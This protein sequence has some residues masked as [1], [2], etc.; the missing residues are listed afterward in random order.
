M[1]RC[2]DNSAIIDMTQQPNSSTT[3]FAP[4][5]GSGAMR[6]RMGFAIQHLLAAAR[7]ARRCGE[8]E[9]ENRGKPIDYFFDEI[10]HCCTA[11]LFFSVASLEA[12]INE[13]FFD[14]EQ[15]FSHQTPDLIAELWS[16]VEEKPILDKYQ[17]V[18]VL[19]GVA[20]FEKGTAPYQDVDS[21]IKARNALVHFKPEWDDDQETLRKVGA[22]LSGKFNL[23][24]FHNDSAPLF[25]HRCVTHG[26]AKW[27]VQASLEFMEA[28]HD[29]A[30]VPHKF[31][32]FERSLD[33]GSI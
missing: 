25:P 29:S 7:F 9:K 22:R 31:S 6:S 8:I 32:L 20:K 30:S 2:S 33:T 3:E 21:L 11:S 15:H 10:L 18:L 4:L 27:A 28:F 14:S 1:V 23:S 17:A 24:P 13:L 12:N 16:L 19:K 5:T 26:C